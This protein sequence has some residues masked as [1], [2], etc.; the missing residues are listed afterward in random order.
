MGSS[1]ETSINLMG[2]MEDEDSSRGS[3][4]TYDNGRVESLI[5]S[6]R[7][8][9]QVLASSDSNQN[10]KMHKSLPRM[11]K[12]VTSFYKLENDEYGLLNNL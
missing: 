11:H 6:L 9:Q 10:N 8:D 3:L 1:A 2:Q 7:D 12:R 4:Y 5:V